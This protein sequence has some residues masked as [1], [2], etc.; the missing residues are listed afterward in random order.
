MRVVAVGVWIVGCAVIAL[1]CRKQGAPTPAQDRVSKP[2]LRLAIVTDLQGQIEPCGCTSD[3]LG[4]I[5]RMA[6]ALEEAA[7]DK[8]PTLLVAIGDTLFGR[9]DIDPAARAQE[10]SRATTLATI[11]AKLE[12]AAVAT[13]PLDAQ[14]QA[15]LADAPSLP[16][17]SPKQKRVHEVG[18]V[19]VGLVSVG[20]E[21]DAL[22]VAETNAKALVAEGADIVVALVV[23]DRRQAM[24]LA[25][26]AAIDFVVLG[27]IDEDT[28]RAPRGSPNGWVLHAGRQGQHVVLVDLRIG[29]GE[30]WDNASGWSRDNARAS[31]DREIADLA[32]KIEAWRADEKTAQS[33]LAAQ[34]QRLKS[35]RDE[36][37]ALD[38]ATKPSARSFDAKRVTVNTDIDTSLPINALIV[39][40]DKKVNAHNKTALA[41]LKPA[42]VAKGQP[43]FVGSNA[44]AS[45]HAAAFAWWKGHPHSHAYRTLEKRYKEYSLDCVG[46]H[47]TGYNEPGGST[48]THNLDGALADVGCESCH[49]PGGNH[50]KAGTAKMILNPSEAMCVTCHN[51]EHSD[52]FDYVPF[53]ETLLVPGH[54]KAVGK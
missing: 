1:A 46:C 4:G 30:G 43:A 35:L 17:L 38:G 48:V 11:L 54:G 31:L 16:V 52:K 22:P 20:S 45:C 12:V 15:L 40:H 5:D 42:P 33:D 34:E 37:A 13:G 24:R 36:R 19:R 18:G 49:G 41:D 26:I 44:C 39:A 7:R 47:V 9:A 50:V 3:P 8:V 29:T 25:G 14:H 32:T 10:Q 21:P 28:P 23:G 51:E 53:R 2:A 6:T 27:G